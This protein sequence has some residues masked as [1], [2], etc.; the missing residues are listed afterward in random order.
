MKRILILTASFGYGHLSTAKAIAEAL[1]ITHGPDCC[2]DIV[3]PFDHPRAPALLREDQ[4]VYDRMVTEQPELYQLGYQVAD[5]WLA[6]RVLEGSM[7]VMLFN[8]LREI[9]GQR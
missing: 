2:V 4:N 7:T 8:A 3:N 6:G 5:T 9:M 1:R